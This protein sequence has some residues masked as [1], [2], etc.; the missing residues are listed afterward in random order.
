MPAAKQTSLSLPPAL[1]R[2]V[3]PVAK[4]EDRT[5]NELLHEAVRHYIADSR[6]RELHE[7]GQ[8][9]ARKLG[10]KESDVQHLIEEVRAGK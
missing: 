7:Y 5:R 1:M 4:R 9:Q 10:L 8:K 2:E 3:E 6:W